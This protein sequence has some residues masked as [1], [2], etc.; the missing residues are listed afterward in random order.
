[1]EYTKDKFFVYEGRHTY[2]DSIQKRESGGECQ[3]FG[4][5]RIRLYQPV[6]AEEIMVTV[7]GIVSF[8]SH[9]CGQLLADNIFCPLSMNRYTIIWINSTDR[10]Q[11]RGG[12]LGRGQSDTVKI[13]EDN[14]Y[15][16]S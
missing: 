2:R 16:R 11:P 4:I 6:V 10:E 14:R 8:D 1:M 5:L 12:F 3:G 9:R 15:C 13:T 7:G